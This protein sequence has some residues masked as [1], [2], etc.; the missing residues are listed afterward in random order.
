[1]AA[2]VSVN[3]AGI[4][5]VDSIIKGLPVSLVMGAETVDAAQLVA[6]GVDGATNFPIVT[7]ITSSLYPAASVFTP[8]GVTGTW[9]N[10][11]RILTIGNAGTTEAGMY[12]GLS[13][14]AVNAFAQI[15]QVVSS[16]QLKLFSSPFTADQVN[17]GY[18]IWWA[19]R[20]YAAAT[21]S[22]L[23]SSADGKLNV[24]KFQ[25]ADSLGNL[26]T[27]TPGTSFYVR[28]VPSDVVVLNGGSFTGQQIAVS[29][30]TFNLLPTWTNKG[31]IASLELVTS[32]GFAWW[33]GTTAEKTWLS[34][35]ARAEGSRLIITGAAA[36]IKTAVIRARSTFGSSR[37]L[38]LVT[39]SVNYDA[40]APVVSASVTASGLS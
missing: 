21:G 33:D 4:S 9:T 22:V 31:G 13:L 26:G 5:A 12:V 38:N 16:T 29:N 11:T 25:A 2:I 7:P 18:Q 27:N 15:E 10:S 8:A 35:A 3:G 28:D 30:P 32:D 23:T 24:L 20:T 34:I 37:Y 14:G 6:A 40:S 1:M 36:G 39:M 17:V 19:Y